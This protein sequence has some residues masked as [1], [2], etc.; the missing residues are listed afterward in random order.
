[1]YCHKTKPEICNEML[2][3]VNRNCVNF[4]YQ[5]KTF[6]GQFTSYAATEILI[7]SSKKVNYSINKDEY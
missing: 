1:M 4:E 5:V 6:G 7:A 2:K 3:E